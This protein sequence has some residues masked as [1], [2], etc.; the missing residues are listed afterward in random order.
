MPLRQLKVEGY[1][2]ALNWVCVSI[3][4]F[5]YLSLIIPAYAIIKGYKTLET[6]SFLHLISGFLN[7][8]IYFVNGM[9]KFT[10]VVY[11]VDFC[12][13]SGII[14]I[15]ISFSLLMFKYFMQKEWEKKLKILA[16][17][18]FIV[19]FIGLTVGFSFLEI[20][21]L[22]NNKKSDPDKK[23]D[24]T[25]KIVLDYIAAIF[26]ILMYFTPG[27]MGMYYMITK[28]SNDYVNIVAEIVGFINAIVW[29]I[30]S[31]K[32]QALNKNEENIHGI[33]A[34]SVSIALI[35]FI[36]IVYVINLKYA[37]EDEDI[38][39]VYKMTQNSK[40]QKSQ[41]SSKKQLKDHNE[42]IVNEDKNKN[43]VDRI[44]SAMDSFY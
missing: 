6:F 42:I 31:A 11:L 19:L 14:F 13:L 35:L 7:S 21:Y 32:L 38:E 23:P 18:G 28:H 17:I 36:C 43:N 3:G 39:S 29:L 4:F 30:W 41:N 34:N 15:F 37:K 9:T 5:F 25:K 12:N 20:L 10:S 33:I 8:L 26:N 40:E 16:Y 24:S 1:N 27:F 2:D 22:G 44:K